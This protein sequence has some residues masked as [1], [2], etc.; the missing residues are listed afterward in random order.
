MMAA[1]RRL[2]RVICGNRRRVA[3]IQEETHAAMEEHAAAA[4]RLETV[5]EESAQKSRQA[6]AKMLRPYSR[7]NLEQIER[8]LQNHHR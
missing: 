4:A 1:L 2:R 8:I 5:I 3:K 7:E 6:R